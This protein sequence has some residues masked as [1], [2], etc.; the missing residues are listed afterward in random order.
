MIG[1]GR[2]AREN[3]SL[4]PGRVPLPLC[5]L[6]ERLAQM[7]Q[8]EVPDRTIGLDHLQ[9]IVKGDVAD[10]R[11]TSSSLPLR[12]A[13]VFPD[14]NLPRRLLGDA[15]KDLWLEVEAS[16]GEIEDST[17]WTRIF[18]STVSHRM[19]EDFLALFEPQVTKV[20]NR[21]LSPLSG[22]ANRLSRLNSLGTRRVRQSRANEVRRGERFA[23]AKRLSESDRFLKCS[24]FKSWP[25]IEMEPGAMSNEFRTL[26]EVDADG[27][28]CHFGAPGSLVGITRKKEQNNAVAFL[29]GASTSSPIPR[30]LAVLRMRCAPSCFEREGSGGVV[31]SLP[32]HR[33]DTP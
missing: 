11:Y 16:V 31:R 27:L 18:G 5:Q 1:V 22:V 24:L 29:P 15:L 19:P 25:R 30:D 23:D 2:L 13:G 33:R 9:G 28:A 14:T 20:M 12:Y 17:D 26:A 21:F 3:R 7:G 10:N 8:K 32:P 4:L 6:L